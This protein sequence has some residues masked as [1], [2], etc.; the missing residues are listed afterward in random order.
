MRP[1]LHLNRKDGREG[2]K[3]LLRVYLS[4]CVRT[5]GHWCPMYRWRYVELKLPCVT[6]AQVIYQQFSMFQPHICVALTVDRCWP[7]HTSWAY[8]H[9]CGY[10]SVSVSA[11]K[12]WSTA[13]ENRIGIRP[14][15]VWQ[16]V[17]HPASWKCRHPLGTLSHIPTPSTACPPLHLV[18]TAR[19]PDDGDSSP[20]WSDIQGVYI[21]LQ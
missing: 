10:V 21:P 19:G 12:G 2:G 14:R 3:D 16:P 9:G 20:W 1:C 18:L 7:E 15:P 4:P 5:C 8:T 6:Q 11:R 13:G 17:W